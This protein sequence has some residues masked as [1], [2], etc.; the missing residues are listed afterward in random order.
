M[1]KTAG[2]AQAAVEP[3]GRVWRLFLLSNGRMIHVAM[4][5]KQYLDAILEGRKRVEC[6]LTQIACA[7]FRRIGE[8]DR[9][10][11]KISAGPFRAT[12]LAGR[13]LF[14]SGLTPKDVADLRAR[15]N[16]LICGEADFWLRKSQAKYA[17]LVWLQEVQPIL[18]GPDVKPQRGLAWLSL[19]DSE[20]VYPGCLATA[21]RHRDS[22]SPVSRNGRG[23]RGAD[24]MCRED[25]S[26]L[27][28]LLTAGNVRNRHVYL[29]RSQWSFFPAS[30]IGG[31]RRAEAGKNVQL[32]LPTGQV[33]RTDIAGQRSMFRTR[34]WGDW[35]AAE[36]VQAGDRLTFRRI[37]LRRYEVNIAHATS[38][39]PLHSA[40][41]C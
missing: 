35:F 25:T 8:G 6:R 12:A 11:F 21:Q 26:T 3:G 17:T 23:H 20:D 37:A 24:S 10:Y 29:P 5:W 28:V 2:G 31:R 33:I 13:V 34:E 15:Y 14:F 1:R 9:I 27:T 39:C 19:Q 32:V 7:P 18:T 16:T 40:H 41:E 36:R 22:P 4:L 30:C 38:T